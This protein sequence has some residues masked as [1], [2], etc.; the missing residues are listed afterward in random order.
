MI[1]KII[2]EMLD[3]VTAARF[4]SFASSGH[5]LEA[6]FAKSSSPCARQSPLQ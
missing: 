2:N 4:E 5:K 3:P 1:G 6:V